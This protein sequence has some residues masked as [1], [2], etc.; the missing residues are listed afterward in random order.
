MAGADLAATGLLQVTHEGL[1]YDSLVKDFSGF[2]QGLIFGNPAWDQIIARG[3]D[4]AAVRDRLVARL[5]E[6]FGDEPASIP[7]KINLYG[8]TV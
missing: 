6:R 8:T 3:G 4:A 7:L 2:A 1:K 5:R